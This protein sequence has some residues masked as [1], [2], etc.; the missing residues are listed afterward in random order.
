MTLMRQNIKLMNNYIRREIEMIDRQGYAYAYRDHLLLGGPMPVVPTTVCKRAAMHIRHRL[1]KILNHKP[2]TTIM[3]YQ[4]LLDM[5]NSLTPTQLSQKVLCLI[6]CDL[7]EFNMLELVEIE[8][9]IT[10]MVE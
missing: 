5:L 9:R 2:S 4:Q 3:T 10:L 7:E 1:E 6:E 8:G